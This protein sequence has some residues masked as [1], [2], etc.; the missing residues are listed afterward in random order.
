MNKRENECPISKPMIFFLMLHFINENVKVEQWNSV[1]V[2]ANSKWEVRGGC[3]VFHN[4]SLFM[5][6]SLPTL[7]SESSHD[8]YVP[9]PSGHYC[10][11]KQRTMTA[12]LQQKKTSD[13]IIWKEMC[14]FN[15]RINTWE[16][17]FHGVA[18]PNPWRLCW[19]KNCTWNESLEV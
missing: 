11:L 16:R 12:S 6:I 17:W 7:F 10:L 1:P 9:L 5:S 3:S 19:N 15:S 2:N 14:M 8:P 4:G 18:A 13:F